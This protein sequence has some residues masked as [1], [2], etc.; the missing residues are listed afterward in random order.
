MGNRTT[1]RIKL[2]R[3]AGAPANVVTV[4]PESRFDEDGNP[5]SAFS[6]W[7]SWNTAETAIPAAALASYD[8]PDDADGKII[9]VETTDEDG[10]VSSSMSVVH[11][12]IGQTVFDEKHLGV[13]FEDYTLVL[14]GYGRFS[15]NHCLAV[16]SIGANVAAVSA[17]DTT[18]WD[19]YGGSIIANGCTFDDIHGEA[20][21]DLAD[22]EVDRTNAVFGQYNSCE[23]KELSLSKPDT[24][25]ITRDSVFD[26]IFCDRPDADLVLGPGTEVELLRGDGFKNHIL[27]SGDSPLKDLNA[28]RG[29]KVMIGTIDGCGNV[30]VDN[31]ATKLRVVAQSGIVND[32]ASAFA[33]HLDITNF[34]GGGSISGSGDTAIGI[35]ETGEPYASPGAQSLDSIKAVQRVHLGENVALAMLLLNDTKSTEVS[36]DLDAGGSIDSVDVGLPQHRTAFTA[37]GTINQLLG[38]HG[39]RTKNRVEI[40][41]GSDADIKSIEDP[42]NYVRIKGRPPGWELA[43]SL[44]II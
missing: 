2:V 25:V 14:A 35:W 29:T 30:H 1:S 27:I 20:Q 26:K 41:L 36:V 10:V 6:S 38:A 3:R 42:S 4:Q 33:V 23:V 19:T 13:P 37:N 16:R 44:K 34:Y 24:R 31:P 22:C 12:G 15:L 9:Y 18:I 21:V 17:V 28:G 5:L 11:T 7:P 43:R 39:A 32:A 8:F 40:T